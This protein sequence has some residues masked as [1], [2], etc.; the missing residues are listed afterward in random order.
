MN[1]ENTGTSALKNDTSSAD[2][3]SS[4]W[5]EESPADDAGMI[6]PLQLYAAAMLRSVL[7]SGELLRKLVRR[8]SMVV[9]LLGL[10]TLLTLLSWS[11]VF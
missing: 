9:A 2:E 4:S 10:V 5:E 3:T 11:D 7:L 6:D 8:L 1:S